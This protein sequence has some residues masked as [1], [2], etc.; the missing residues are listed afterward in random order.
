LK[1]VS[2]DSI[3]PVAFGAKK[4]DRALA[5]QVPAVNRSAGSPKNRDEFSFP[6]KNLEPDYRCGAK[7]ELKN[8]YLRKHFCYHTK[9]NCNYQKYIYLPI[10]QKP[11]QINFHFHNGNIGKPTFSEQF[12][13]PLKIQEFTGCKKSVRNLKDCD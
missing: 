5:F 8:F 13:K 2:A 3:T 6:P 10:L 9:S 4:Y 12:R 11:Q 7:S 1:P